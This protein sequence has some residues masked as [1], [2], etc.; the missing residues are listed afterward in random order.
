MSRLGQSYAQANFV[1]VS[2]VDN[3][4]RSVDKTSPE[5]IKC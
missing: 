2:F 3:V 4:Y 5:V 1:S